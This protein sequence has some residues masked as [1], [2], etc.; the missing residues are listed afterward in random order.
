MAS[1]RQS[2]SWPPHAHWLPLQT[3]HWKL[4]WMQSQRHALVS[5]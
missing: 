5:H 2:V 4:F 1:C 3:A